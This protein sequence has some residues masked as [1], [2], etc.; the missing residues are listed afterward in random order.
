MSPIAASMR[1]VAADAILWGSI[2]TGGAQ[3][4]PPDEAAWLF[5]RAKLNDG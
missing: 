2:G 4:I 1:M 3:A 5:R